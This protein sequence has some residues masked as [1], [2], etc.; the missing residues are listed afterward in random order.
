M[1]F[2]GISPLF[3]PVQVLWNSLKFSVNIMISSK[4]LCYPTYVNNVYLFSTI[5]L[6][7]IIFTP[8]FI[9]SNTLIYELTTNISWTSLFLLQVQTR[10]VQQ[11]I[12]PHQAT[13]LCQRATPSCPP[14]PLVM[15]S[16]TLLT[17]SAMWR[18]RLAWCRLWAWRHRLVWSPPLQVGR[19][20]KR[21]RMREGG[22]RVKQKAR[23]RNWV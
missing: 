13:P 7:G 19:F 10:A 23:M 8:D 1:Y 9:N 2:L 11:Q 16:S 21:E 17:S 20:F 3:N 18:H 6:I 22:R 5:M 14:P 15:T 12:A 4:I